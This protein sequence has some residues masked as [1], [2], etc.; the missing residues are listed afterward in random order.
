MRV[1]LIAFCIALLVACDATSQTEQE[2]VK[3]EF[4]EGELLVSFLNVGQGDATLLQ[5]TDTTILIDAGRHDRNDVIDLLEGAGVKEVDLFI[6][7]H[8]HADHIGQ[9]DQVLLHFPVDEVWMSGDLHTT[10]TFERTIQAIASSGASYYEPRAGE[11]F[12]I[13]ALEIEVLNPTELTG[14]FHEGAIALRVQHGEV[15]WLFMSDIEED[16][17]R[18]LVDSKV[19]IE[20][21]V[22]RLGHHGS[23]TSSHEAFLQEVDP[24]Y[25]IYSSGVD[26]EYGH[27]HREVIERLDRLEIEWF[28]TDVHGQIDMVS[29]GQEIIVKSEKEF[30]QQSSPDATASTCIHLN[31]ATIEELVTIVHIGE[32][33]AEQIVAMRPINQIEQL[34]D[35]QGIGQGRLS[36]I[37]AE[38]LAC[39]D[40][41]S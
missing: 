11:Q 26:N 5:T 8:P 6:G 32:E 9:A 7:T 20:A 30:S 25:A 21:D 23:S 2:R 1:M 28:G 31:E 16:V 29:D 27:P 35:I 12:K 37:V 36:D 15:V 14:D 40:G 17:E 24:S 38:E 33:R 39:L 3:T 10:R 34:T 18:K 4:Q 41:G 19:N 22:L 13:G